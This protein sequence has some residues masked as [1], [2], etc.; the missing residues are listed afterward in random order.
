MVHET[1]YNPA[2]AW[3]QTS[4]MNFAYLG[5]QIIDISNGG[6]NIASMN[7]PAYFYAGLDRLLFK[8]QLDVC[9]LGKLF[10][11]SWVAFADQVVH[12]DKIDVP[13]Q[14]MLALLHLVHMG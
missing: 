8:R 14:A 1:D 5:I 2:R 7:S 12:D 11:R 9:F 13:A 3:C 6:I 10:R 4:N